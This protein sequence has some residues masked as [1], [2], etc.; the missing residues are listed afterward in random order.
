MHREA[1]HAALMS[2]H[3][4]AERLGV[5]CF[6]GVDEVA[7]RLLWR[8]LTRA[9]RAARASAEPSAHG[10]IIE[11]ARIRQSVD[12]GPWVARGSAENRS[13]FRYLVRL[14]RRSPRVPKL[15][16]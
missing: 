12:G 11:H 6:G 13:Y 7:I 10:K 1:K 8:H 14:R 4:G 16:S 9:R 3:E 5:T 2:S 15:L